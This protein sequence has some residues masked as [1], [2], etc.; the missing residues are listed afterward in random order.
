[1]ATILAFPE[2]RKLFNDTNLPRTTLTKLTNQEFNQRN[3]EYFKILSIIDSNQNE[4]IFNHN[5]AVILPSIYV[6][7]IEYS[8]T[9]KIR[10]TKMLSEV[11]SA[12]GLK[13]LTLKDVYDI[14]F[15]QDKAFRMTGPSA[16]IIPYSLYDEAVTI[17]MFPLLVINTT[18]DKAIKTH[19]SISSAMPFHNPDQIYKIPYEIAKPFLASADKRFDP[20]KKLLGLEGAAYKSIYDMPDIIQQ[21]IGIE[22]TKPVSVLHISGARLADATDINKKTE[23]I[24]QPDCLL[25]EE[26]HALQLNIM[27]KGKVYEGISLLD[28]YVWLKLKVL[29]TPLQLKELKYINYNWDGFICVLVPYTSKIKILIDTDIKR[30]MFEA[31]DVK[32]TSYSH[33]YTSLNTYIISEKID[34]ELVSHT[35]VV[36]TFPVICYQVAALSKVNPLTIGIIANKAT[37]KDS[38]YPLLLSRGYN[39]LNSDDYGRVLGILFEN[40]DVT[41]PD[42]YSSPKAQEPD[43]LKAIDLYYS[44]NFDSREILFP[45]IFEQ[46]M[47]KL[48]HKMVREK[49]HTNNFTWEMMVNG[50][51]LEYLIAAFSKIYGNLVFRFPIGKFYELATLTIKNKLYQIYSDTPYLPTSRWVFMGHMSSEVNCASAHVNVELQAPNDTTLSIMFRAR[52][53]DKKAEI[54]LTAYYAASNQTNTSVISIGWMRYLL[55]FDVVVVAEIR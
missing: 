9:A 26:Q 5:K 10:I 49:G 1:M 19:Y 34:L 29:S 18:T 39:V 25:T 17:G 23:I 30:V 32:L 15:L 52:N 38:L 27:R 40:V 53:S 37:G 12:H 4:R 6:C 36:K 28:T 33:T 45:S 42:F 16:F 48:M 13:N 14:R 54:L 11:E 24:L 46:E 20:F 3:T 31:L 35:S 22:I 51:R 55:S 47:E 43:M 41:S 50:Q 44:K 7:H 21:Q 8:I 2:I